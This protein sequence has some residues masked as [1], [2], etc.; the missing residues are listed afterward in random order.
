MLF[1]Y[2]SFGIAP[3]ETKTLDQII[4]SGYLV[5]PRA[6]GY[7]GTGLLGEAHVGRGC[8]G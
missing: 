4:T 5:G 3:K 8:A 2:F 7:R 6:Q 1:F